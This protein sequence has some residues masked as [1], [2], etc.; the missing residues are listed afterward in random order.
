MQKTAVLCSCSAAV[1]KSDKSG[2]AV[3]HEALER[4]EMM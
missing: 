3:V 2:A 4:S 1:L